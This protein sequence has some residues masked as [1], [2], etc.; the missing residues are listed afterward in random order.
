[1]PGNTKLKELQKIDFRLDE[2]NARKNALGEK[3]RLDNL[4]IESSK[5]SNVLKTK[6]ESLKDTEHKQKKIE[7]ELEL[8]SEKIKKEENKLYGGSITNPK[9]LTAVQ[10]EVNFLKK[11]QDEKET[12]ILE[13]LDLI[14]GMKAET[15]NFSKKVKELNAEVFE[16]KK[17]Y[18]RAILE[19]EE[20]LARL[21]KLREETIPDIS[22]QHLEIYKE[23]RK[24]KGGVVVVELIEGI[25][26]G[27]S[28]ELSAKEVDKMIS[29]DEFWR[30]P[31][32][33]RIIIK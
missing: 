1:M 3:E 13:V 29:S 10:S 7:D 27:C 16:A 31:N 19:I 25:C 20:E 8:L 17:A 5:A 22:P 11:R 15:E 6:E 33:R 21:A 14:D 4:N 24:K 9:E 18:E 32:C 30:C 23:L 2:L 12:E 28:T 26:Q